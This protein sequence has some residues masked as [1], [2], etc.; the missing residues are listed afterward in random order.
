MKI[1][2]PILEL[3]E[4]L[5]RLPGLETL[6]SCCGHGKAPI[7]IFFRVEEGDARGL[8]L[9][10]RSAD[11]RYWRHGGAWSIRVSVGDEPLR[12]LPILYLLESTATGRRAYAQ[13]RD[14]VRSIQEH[15]EHANFMRAYGLEEVTP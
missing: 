9:L 15:L 13:G 10:A 5:N 11:R 14:L 3:V 1:D 4:A 7:A 2:P 6:E 12:P 8:F